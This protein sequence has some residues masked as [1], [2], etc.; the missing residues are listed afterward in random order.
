VDGRHLR[1]L[2]RPRGHAQLDD[3]RIAVVRVT[4][5]EANASVDGGALARDASDFRQLLQTDSLFLNGRLA[6]FYG[7]ELP[8]DAPFQ[9]VSLSE[10]ERAGV[11]THPYLMATFAYTDTSSPI[12]RGVFLARSVLGRALK[13]PPEAF[14]PLPAELHPNLTTRERVLLQTKPDACAK[15]HG[16][17]NP[18]GFTLENFDAVGRFR[19]K[20]SGKPIDATGGYQSRTGESVTLSG[21]RDLASFLA[22]SEEVHAAFV[23]QLFQHTVKQPVRAYGP[24]TLADL[25]RSFEVNDFNIRKLIVQ[26]AV[27]SATKQ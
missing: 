24:E 2:S 17:I 8:A 25:V 27:V 20:E 5:H 14:A 6:K 23:E 3:S 12:H 1:L 22:D 9:L 21:V 16:M 18:L 19:D 15:C 7:A 26:I 10:R 4:H 11:L 13:P